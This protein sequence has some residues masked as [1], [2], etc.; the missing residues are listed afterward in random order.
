MDIIG[1]N[2]NSGEH[3]EGATIEEQAKSKTPE[4]KELEKLRK[5]INHPRIKEAIKHAKRAGE[6]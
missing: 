3:Y 2:G 4:I 6:L 1:Q 5:Q